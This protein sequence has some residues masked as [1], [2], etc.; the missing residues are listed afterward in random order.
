[1][2]IEIQVRFSDEFRVVV[3]IKK[4][5]SHDKV[6]LCVALFSLIGFLYLMYDD[7]ILTDWSDRPDTAAIGEIA[8]VRGDVRQKHFSRFSWKS[9]RRG[10]GLFEG[11]SIFTGAAGSAVVVLKDGTKV[12]LTPNSLVSFNVKENQ[13]ALNLQFGTFKGQLA[14]PGSLKVQVGDETV[15]LDG[16]GAQVELKSGNGVELTVLE[17]NLGVN[18][19]GSTTQ[20]DPSKMLTINSQP[21]KKAALLESAARARSMFEGDGEAPRELKPL[22]KQAED[23]TEAKAKKAKNAF[24]KITE[25]A[26][27]A[28]LSVRTDESSQPTEKPVVR[29]KWDDS[30]EKP[31]SDYQVQMAADPYFQDVI[32]TQESK[33]QEW[34][35]PPLTPSS[36]YVRVR[37][38][39]EKREWS[40]PVPFDFAY[41]PPGP[42]PPP[43]A[44][45]APAPRIG[46]ATGEPLAF[47]WAPV[48]RAD[49]YEV[50]VSRDPEFTNVVRRAT[51]RDTRF[52]L[53]YDETGSYFVRV[54]AVSAKGAPG[55]FQNLGRV[56]IGNDQP[57]LAQVDPISILAAT[58]E[59]EPEPVPVALQWSPAPLAKQYEIELSET[60]D[61]AVSQKL[62]STNPKKD[63]RL[64]RPGTTYYRVRGLNAA[65]TAVTEYSSSGQLRYDFRL[66]LAAPKLI[67]PIAGVTLFFQQSKSTPFWMGWGSVRQATTYILQIGQ[68]PEFSKPVLQHRTDQLSFLMKQNLP[69]G[70]LYWRVKAQNTERESHWSE[71]RALTVL[72]GRA[73]ASGNSNSKTKGK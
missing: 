61:F 8:S 53:N 33:K 71:P 6:I 27:N 51:T 16:S 4:L 67:E 9:L 24:V 54:R 28:R 12:N 3:D 25:P 68:D 66:P 1:M 18:S 64:K 63:I 30:R 50:E 23:E 49:H 10:T 47:T 70:K 45:S 13:M 37:P 46:N 65:G 15:T 21:G 48:L 19:G 62:T 20:L 26:P 40:E 69:L 32:L 42:M 56:T 55:D 43:K 17:G 14:S 72:G 7:S 31:A 2:S 38:R 59:A 36:Y 22:P 44:L 58:P 29:I 11:D 5:N 52:L 39:S 35:T 57:L 73:P 34:T 41:Q 60:P